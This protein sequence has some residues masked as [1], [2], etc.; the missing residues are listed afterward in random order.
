MAKDL[1]EAKALML[2]RPCMF[3]E[4]QCGWHS[5]LGEWQRGPEVG[6]GSEDHIKKEFGS[7]IKAD[8]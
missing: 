2:K 4:Q 3:E 5:E 6:S 1:A 7:H 8:Q